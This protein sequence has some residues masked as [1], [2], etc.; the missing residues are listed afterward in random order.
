[1]LA[2]ETAINGW[3]DLFYIVATVALIIWIVITLTRR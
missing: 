1:M 3:A 2:F